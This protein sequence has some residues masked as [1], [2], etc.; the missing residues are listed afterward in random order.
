V[1]QASYE[2]NRTRLQVSNFRRYH[3]FYEA[4]VDHG[5]IYESHYYHKAMAG[6]A[7]GNRDPRAFLKN[8]EGVYH[9]DGREYTNAVM[10]I[11]NRYDLDQG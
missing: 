6:L 8:I 4:M 3:N 9:D 11:I 7:A 5:S 10:S 2:H 1:R